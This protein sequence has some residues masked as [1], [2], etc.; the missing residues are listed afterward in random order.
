MRPAQ[1]HIVFN[2]D[3]KGLDPI[4]VKLPKAPDPI[5]I[6]NLD[7]IQREQ[8]FGR[9]PVPERLA[10]LEEIV[11]RKEKKKDVEIDDIW[12]E[13]EANP[14]YYEKEID[15]IRKVWWHIKNGYWFMCNGVPTYITGWHFFYLNFW[16]LDGKLPEYRDRDR[17]FFIFAEFCWKDDKCYGFL[18]PK[19]RREGATSKAA[20]INYIMTIMA[21]NYNSGIQSMTDEHAKLVFQEHIVSAWKRVPFFMRP[22]YSGTSDPKSVLDFNPPANKRGSLASSVVGLDSSIS[23]RNSKIKA[24]DAYKLLF[25][26]QDEIGKTENVD[27]IQRWGTVKKVLAT[28]A[29]RFIHGFSIGTSTVGEMK[30]GGGQ[31]FKKFCKMSRYSERDKNGQTKSGLYVLF[32][33]ATEG[34]DGFVGPYGESIVNTPTIEQ[35]DYLF[36]QWESV[37]KDVAE[38]QS[39]GS[40]EYLKNQRDILEEGEDWENLVKVIQ[41]H[42]IYF[43]DCFYTT[44]TESG[45]NRPKI[46]RRIN[47]ID[48]MTDAEIGIRR[49]RFEFTGEPFISDVVWRDYQMP[50]QQHFEVSKLL[51]PEEANL[52]YFDRAYDTFKPQMPGQFIAGGDPFKYNKTQGRRMSNGAGSVFWNFDPNI[53]GEKK[54]SEDWESNRF[55]CNYNHRPKS[56]RQYVIDMA[57]MCKYYRA[58]MF[59]EIDNTALLDG[60]QENGFGGYLIYMLTKG[61][62]SWRENPGSTRAPMTQDI[63]TLLMS[64]IEDNIDR[65]VHLDLLRQ[66]HDIE[67]PEQLT[68]YDLVASS[69]YALIGA[70]QS[71][72]SV[73]KDDNKKSTYSLDDYF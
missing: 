67:G 6:H 40:F 29:G 13:M 51:T 20:C 68:D 64:H 55:V 39:M 63:F 70:Q 17:K 49:G 19:H 16:H 52:N 45:F 37:G 35:K 14:S 50:E 23:F 57:A 22:Y 4:T 62:K 18:Y 25:Y 71:H 7:K 60:F 36:K 5:Y 69:G 59:P 34:M 65:E 11:S 1:S 58:M 21:L 73:I 72:V 44:T 33:P 24:Y 42:P 27:V 2:E 61:K 28:G 48:E 31:T 47:I 43:N 38:F 26:H 9:L 53:D 41:E 8:K 10:R 66:W 54:Y 30:S 46:I 15:Y 32:I 56:K 3:Q 12:N